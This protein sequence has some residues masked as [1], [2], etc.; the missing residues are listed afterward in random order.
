[1]TGRK[2]EEEKTA[3]NSLISAVDSPTSP[4]RSILFTFKKRKEIGDQN[5]NSNYRVCLCPIRKKEE[6][7]MFIL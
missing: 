5:E 1:M 6:L 7:L 3:T 4:R 2:K